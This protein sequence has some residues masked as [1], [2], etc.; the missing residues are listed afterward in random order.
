[1]ADVHTQTSRVGCIVGTCGSVRCKTCKHMSQGNCFVSNVTRKSYTISSSMNCA[2]HNVIYLI[3]CKK[4][5]VQYVGETNQTLRKRLNG[6]RTHLRKLTNLYN[7][8][9]KHFTSDGHSE[10]DISIMPI[11]EIAS[12]GANSKEMRLDREEYWCRE[13]CTIYPYGLNDNVY[14]EM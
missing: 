4:C 6:H 13:L 12:N 8:I 1:M 11:E 7:S 2:T 14:F 9:Y 3:S 5:D 10:D